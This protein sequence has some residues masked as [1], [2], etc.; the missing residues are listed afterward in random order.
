MAM[1]VLRFG[2]K[3]YRIWRLCQNATHTPST[4]EKETTKKQCN[5]TNNDTK[6]E[7]GRTMQDDLHG[8]A[9]EFAST[10]GPM[11]LASAPA[12]P[13]SQRALAVQR[14]PSA[15]GLCRR[16]DMDTTHTMQVTF[17]GH[18]LASPVE[19]AKAAI[20]RPGHGSRHSRSFKS[21]CLS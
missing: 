16:G 2:K 7:L 4:V 18:P 17:L 14:G 3:T 21:R 8:R 5:P 13:P 6:P 19:K 12:Q 20:A 15:P 9:L 10:H 11:R 1:A